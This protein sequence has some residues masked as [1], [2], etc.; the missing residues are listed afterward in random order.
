M[1][2]KRG[3]R[4]LWRLLVEEAAEDEIEQAAAV[5]VTQAE[6]ELAAAGFDVAA[7]RATGEAL[8]ARLLGAGRNGRNGKGA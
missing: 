8:V 2:P 4:D 7:E 3:P 5:T 1:T 6:A